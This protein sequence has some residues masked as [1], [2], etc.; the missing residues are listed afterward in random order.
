M[1]TCHLSVNLLQNLMSQWFCFILKAGVGCIWVNFLSQGS[2]HGPS[3]FILH[4]APCFQRGNYNTE[5]WFLP[6]CKNPRRTRPLGRS[7]YTGTVWGNLKNQSMSLQ[8]SI[9]HLQSL[10]SRGTLDVAQWGHR[11][12]PAAFWV[13]QASQVIP[14]ELGFG[15]AWSPHCQVLLSPLIFKPMCIL[16]EI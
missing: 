16:R 10:Q 5:L 9:F 12:K 4:Q 2:C 8:I 7:L 15:K 13:C 3:S 11:A 1:Y 14:Q 6:R